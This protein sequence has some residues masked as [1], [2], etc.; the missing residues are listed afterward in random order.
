MSVRPD[1]IRRISR[2]VISK[3]EA[4]PPAPPEGSG[5]EG[6]RLIN[7]SGMRWEQA[8]LRTVNHDS[9]IWEDVAVARGA[10]TN[11]REQI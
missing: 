11:G 6:S 2:A 3:S 7:D 9:S 4:V 1:R 5:E 10:W 8:G